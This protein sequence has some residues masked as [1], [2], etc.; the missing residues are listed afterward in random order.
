MNIKKTGEFTLNYEQLFQDERFQA[1][2]VEMLIENEQMID[3]LATDITKAEDWKK[4][5]EESTTQRT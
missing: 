5:D 2:I 4:H 1:W 3:P